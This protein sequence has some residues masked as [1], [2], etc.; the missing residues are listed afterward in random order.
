MKMEVR[1]RDVEI[2]KS[3]RA[4]VERRL[5]FA[6]DRF[7]ARIRTVRLRLADINGSR[8]GV[9]KSC[10]L[11]VSLARTSPITI[12]SRAS[13]VR[14]AIDTVAGKVGRV[15]A[16]RFNRKHEFRQFR[17]AAKSLFRMPLLSGAPIKSRGVSPL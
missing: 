10:L 14:G 3:L 13:T 6:L 5:S 12:E 4:Y 16:Q 15:V 17:N 1:G 11:D 9:D 8:G 2:T 7:A